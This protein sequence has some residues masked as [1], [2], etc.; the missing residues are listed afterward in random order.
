MAIIFNEE[1]STFYLESKNLTYAFKISAGYLEHLYFGKKIGRDDLSYT[2][3]AGSNPL[4]SFAP[5]GTSYEFFA[6]EITFFGTGDY[7]EPTVHVINEN[8]DRLSELL[9]D[10]FDILDE[11]PLIS[12]MPSMTGG[13]TLVIHLKDA[14]TLFCADLYYTLY[15]DC[16]VLSRRIVYKNNGENKITL[17]RAYSFTLQLPDNNYNVLSLYGSWARERA[18]QKAP[19]VKGVITIDSKKTT[20]SNILNPFMAVLSEDAT[21]TNGMAVGVSLVYSSSFALKAQGTHRGDTI[22]TGGINDFDFAWILEKGEKL[23][24][25]EAVIAYSADGIGA[26]S[27]AFHDAFRNHLINKNFVFKKRPLVI[28]NWEGTEFHFTEEKIKAIIDGATNTNLDT[29]VLDDG[30]FGVREN[31]KSGL[32][33]WYVNTD[34]LPCGIKGISDYAHEKGFKFGLWFEPEM[35]N[36]DSDLYRAHPDFAIQSENRPHCA[37]RGGGQL[38]LD[39]T[40]ADVRDYIAEVINKVIRENGIDY[41]KWDSNRFVTESVS[42]NLPAERQREF[43]HRYALG[44]YDLMDKI[45]LANPN[46]FFE[47]CSGGGARFDPAMLYYFPQIWTSDNSDAQERTYIQYGTS[48][49]YPLSSMSCHVTSPHRR[50]TTT[51]KTRADIAGLGTFGYELDASSFTDEDRAQAREVVNEYTSWNADLVLNGD[52]YRIENPFESN[53]FAEAIVSKDKTKAILVCYQ[54]TWIYNAHM[55]HIKMA[56]LD[57]NKTYYVPELDK[58]FK[59]STLLNVGFVMNLRS[60]FAT[61]KYHFIEK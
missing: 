27:R 10:G 16:D 52:L 21:E 40:R 18:I 11:K 31:E 61:V 39:I 48:I 4:H 1:T 34:K 30:W 29:F 49:C 44:L 24:T 60:D 50:P 28:N 5:H 26:M 32:G 36:I 33:D 15:D 19:L 46:V 2:L 6:P 53:Y 20:S 3:T 25:P 14:V 12:N 42:K 9:Y 41:V 57:E 59:G 7:R 45:I 43:A 51:L 35:L 22:I 56:G 58:T 37:G 47:G 17:D 13:E 8:G 23:E 54:R 55:K 38:V